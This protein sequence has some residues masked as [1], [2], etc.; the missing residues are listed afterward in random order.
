[1]TLITKLLS[2]GGVPDHFE[3]IRHNLLELR[4]I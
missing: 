2:A 4:Y 1:M 3:P